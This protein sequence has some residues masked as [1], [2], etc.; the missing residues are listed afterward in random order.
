HILAVRVVLAVERNRGTQL[1]L[2]PDRQVVRFPAAAWRGA[3]S[4]VQ[5]VQE[6]ERQ[7]RIANV[8]ASQQPVPRGATHLVK[9]GY[10][11][12][13]IITRTRCTPH[14]LES[15]SRGRADQLLGG[16]LRG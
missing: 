4:R 8:R 13:A 2:R 11:A 5:R 7:E 12:H 16:R 14:E 9:V 10:E 1:A 3:T 15:Q 6:V